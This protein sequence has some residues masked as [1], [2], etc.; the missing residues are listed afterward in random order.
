MAMYDK[1]RPYLYCELPGVK[2]YCC[3][4]LSEEPPYCDGSHNG[5]Q[6]KRRPYITKVDKPKQVALCGCGQ[7]KQLPYCD[8]AHEMLA[9]KPTGK[10]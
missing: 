7:S 6:V 3:C 1:K 2:T 8:G 5:K 4:G 9:G 10:E